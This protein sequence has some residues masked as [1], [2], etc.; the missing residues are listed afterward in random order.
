MKDLIKR[1]LD[2][3]KLILIEQ[4]KLEEKKNTENLI[5]IIKNANRNLLLETNE[6][7]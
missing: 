5:D 3:E 1:K 2:E 6:E 7:D 4:K